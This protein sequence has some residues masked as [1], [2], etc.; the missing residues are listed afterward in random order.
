MPKSMTGY[1]KVERISKEYRVSCE[2]KALNSRYLNIELNC[3]SFLSSREIELTKLIQRYVKRGKVFLKLFVEFLVPPADALRIDFGLA[4][5]YYDGLEEL[6]TKLGIPEPVNL[7][8]LLRFRELVKFELSEEQEERIWKICE[9][10]VEEALQKLDLERER[11]GQQLSKQLQAIVEGLNALTDKLR[12]TANGVLPPLK[13]KLR[14]QIQ[15]LLDN[16]QIDANLFENLVAMSLQKLDIRE[17]IDRLETH[18][19]KTMELLSSKEA[20]GSHLDFLAQEILR[21]LNTVLS[22]SEDAGLIDLALR[23]KVLISQFREQVQNLE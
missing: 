23:G 16:A 18:L 10:V 6:V 5:A 2:V 21:E 3:P 13:E 7:D 11:E 14:N 12:E 20:V 4:K 22:K 19:S 1:A 9:E 15:Q 17:E 8:Q